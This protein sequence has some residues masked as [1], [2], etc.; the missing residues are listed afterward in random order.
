MVVSKMALPALLRAQTVLQPMAVRAVLE[1]MRR[2]QPGRL[3]RARSVLRVRDL[4]RE[5]ASFR[6]MSLRRVQLAAARKSGSA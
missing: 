3:V 5:A 1:R 4:R 6:T 2:A